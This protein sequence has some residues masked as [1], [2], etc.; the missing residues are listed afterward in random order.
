MN[1]HQHHKCITLVMLWKV[2]WGPDQLLFCLHAL[3]YTTYNLEIRKI[4]IK[5]K[6][7]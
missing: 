5:C 2:T 7:K 3:V 4:P 6:L 1:E